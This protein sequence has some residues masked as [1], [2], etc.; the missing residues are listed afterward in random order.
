MLKKCRAVMGLS[1]AMV[2]FV[3]FTCVPILPYPW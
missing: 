2:V 1:F 3:A